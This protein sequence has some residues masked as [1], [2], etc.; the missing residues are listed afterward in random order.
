MNAM[1]APVVLPSKTPKS[2]VQQGVIAMNPSVYAKPIILSIA[3]G[4]FAVSCGSSEEYSLL[5]DSSDPGFTEGM[6]INISSTVY[7]LP[8]TCDAATIQ[9]QGS[10]LCNGKILTYTGEELPAFV[11]PPPERQHDINGML[12]VRGC[13]REL[14]EPLQ[15]FASAM[16]YNITLYVPELDSEVSGKNLSYVDMYRDKT[17]KIVKVRKTVK[18][19]G[20]IRNMDTGSAFNNPNSQYYR[21]APKPEKLPID[22]YVGLSE[23]LKI[24]P[25]FTD[26]RIL[27]DGD[28][29]PEKCKN[30]N[31]N[32]PI[33]SIEVL[34]WDVSLYGL[35]YDE[36]LL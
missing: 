16:T 17:D 8:I 5:F 35:T 19:D 10:G 11:N 26:K 25:K 34:D 28:Y 6:N 32:L 3:V 18:H 33:V 15:V 4:V 9:M 24:L 13:K 23:N 21:G 20:C 31:W 30:F 27:H 2:T 1:G 14:L 7:Y 22:L 12:N 29:V 36:D